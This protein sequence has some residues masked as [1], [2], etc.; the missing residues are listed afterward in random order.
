LRLKKLGKDELITVQANVQCSRYLY[1]QEKLDGPTCLVGIGWP[2]ILGRKKKTPILILKFP[3]FSLHVPSSS[4]L[5]QPLPPIVTAASP[6]RRCGRHTRAAGL[7]HLARAA[8]RGLLD[9]LLEP[10]VVEKMVLDYTGHHKMMKEI[11]KI[12]WKKK[13]VNLLTCLL[14]GVLR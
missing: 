8:L 12:K 10:Q 14:K 3:M 2:S 7:L 13:N 6:R 1:V 4:H 5:A 11:M 9:P